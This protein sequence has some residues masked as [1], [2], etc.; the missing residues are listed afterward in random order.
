M[1]FF[2]QNIQVPG[3]KYKNF[4]ECKSQ[5]HFDCTCH[6]LFESKTFYSLFIIFSLNKIV[7]FNESKS[8]NHRT[9]THIFIFVRIIEVL[10][11][12]SQILG[13]WLICHVFIILLVFFLW[14]KSEKSIFAYLNG[15]K[16]S[17][18]LLFLSWLRRKKTPKKV[19]ID[20]SIFCDLLSPSFNLTGS[21]RGLHRLHLPCY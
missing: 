16:R 21:S 10:N 3:F 13:I 18:D 12:F 2:W 11:V 7:C 5:N 20:K 14:K 6:W 15:Y 19:V 1:H 4:I 9:Y 17:N 8:T